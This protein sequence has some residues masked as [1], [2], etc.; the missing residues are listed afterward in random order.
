MVVHIDVVATHTSHLPATTATVSG[1]L[2]L[3][4]TVRVRVSSKHTSGYYCYCQ[5]PAR[6]SSYG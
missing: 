4:A 2:G 3:V 1:L 5:R 6:A